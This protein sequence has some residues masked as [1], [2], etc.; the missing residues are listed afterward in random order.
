MMGIAFV[1]CTVNEKPVF[2]KVENIQVNE[3][4]VDTI[5]LSADVFFMNPNDVGGKLRSDGI[6]V[7][8][9]DIKVGDV[10][11]ETFPVPAR[12]EF[13]IPLKANIPAKKV[14]EEN[15]GGVL[16]G[17]LNSILTNKV[18][19]QYQGSITYSTFG[20]SYEYP[21]EITEEVPI[22]YWIVT[23]RIWDVPY[24]WHKEA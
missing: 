10:T 17:I 19:V 16:G 8:I 24:S 14:F 15:Q 18:K 12:E 13:S 4:N 22:K 5:K 20:L 7:Y 2:V 11:A 1:S 6:D 21:I 9:N 3:A 23:K